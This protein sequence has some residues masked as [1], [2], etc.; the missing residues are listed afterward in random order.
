MKNLKYIFVIL[1]IGGLVLT[2]KNESAADDINSAN[3]EGMNLSTIENNTVAEAKPAINVAGM[4]FMKASWYGPKFHGKLT[5][6]GEVYDQMAFTAAHKSLPFGTMLKLTN[7]ENGKSVIVRINDRGPYIKGRDI[8]LSKGAAIA[9][10]SIK[11]GVIKVKV[12]Q[13]VV[14]NGF[15]PFDSF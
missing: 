5:A 11:P 12:E 7:L 14:D 15:Q 9:L 3:I 1:L 4:G 10:G 2:V 8:D 6:N 13:L